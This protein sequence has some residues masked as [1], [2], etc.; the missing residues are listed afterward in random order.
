MKHAWKEQVHA[1]NV[2][3]DRGKK[4]AVHELMTYVTLNYNVG[5]QYL[6]KTRMNSV[7]HV[8]VYHVHVV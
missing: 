5:V 2:S 8:H 3:T 1:N 6:C 4:R 7:L